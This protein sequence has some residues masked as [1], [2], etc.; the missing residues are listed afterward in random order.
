MIA[1]ALAV[2]AYGVGGARAATKAKVAPPNSWTLPGGDLQNSRYVSGPIDASNVSTL[3]V[4]WTVPIKAGGTFGTYVASPG[5]ANGVMYTQD[6]ASNVEA[7]DVA[8]GKVFCTHD[9]DSTSVGPN[10]VTVGNGVV[11]EA[12]ADSALAPQAST[13]KQLWIRKLTRNANEGI[14][15]APGFKD[16]TVSVSSLSPQGNNLKFDT[17]KLTAKAG[18]VTIKFTNN[19]A[20]AD[21]VLLTNSAN[22]ILGRTSSFDGG[23]KTFSAALKP[24]PTPTTAPCQATVRQAFKER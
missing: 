15:M 8:S 4:A 13:G 20:L 6:L 7:I 5:V 21:N 2:V 11:Y 23:S 1:T 18:K 12:T 19:S 3:G 10:G 17:S 16:V 22:K 24:V 9:Y 14:D